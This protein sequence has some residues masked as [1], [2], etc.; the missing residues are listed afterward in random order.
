MDLIGLND[1]LTFMYLFYLLTVVGLDFMR[2]VASKASKLDLAGIYYYDYWIP[3]S[4]LLCLWIF[5]DARKGPGNLFFEPFFLGVLIGFSS[6]AYHLKILKSP[7][8]R[9]ALMILLPV[10]TPFLDEPRF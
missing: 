2:W 5:L 6:F 8:N 10:M 1:Y 9:I 7:L 3:I 4:V